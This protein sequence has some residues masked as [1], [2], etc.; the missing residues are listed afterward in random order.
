M[1]KWMDAHNRWNTPVFIL[2]ESYGTLR[3]AVVADKFFYNNSM[4]R[5]SCNTVHISGIIMLGTALDH[6]QK[7]FPIDEAVQNLSAIAASNWYYH[8]EGKPSREEFMAEANEFAYSDY[9]Q[10]LALGDRLSDEKREHVLER[11]E[12]FTGLGREVL[13]KDKLRVKTVTYPLL[14]LQKEGYLISRYDARFKM[15]AFKD[16]SNY[17]GFGDDVLSVQGMP[18]FTQ[19]FSGIWRYRL[20]I[21]TEALY[22]ALSVSANNK[23]DF[24]TKKPPVRCLESAMRR[25]PEMKVMFCNGCYDMTTTLGYTEYVVANHDLPR[26]RIRIESYESGHMPYMGEACAAKLGRDLHEFIRWTCKTPN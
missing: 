11:L 21:E 25:N 13:L 23:W 3:N 2:G 24:H 9:I 5:C 8:S 17:D 12:Y 1:N 4:G 7:P 14:A 18:I 22:D 16:Y 19:C 10:A 26:D 15:P 20:N 6:G